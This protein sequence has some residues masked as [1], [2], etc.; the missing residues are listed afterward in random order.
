MRWSCRRVLLAS[1]TMAVQ[2]LSGDDYEMMAMSGLVIGGFA[3]FGGYGSVWRAVL[4]VYVYTIINNVLNLI[5]AGA[6]EQK[7]GCPGSHSGAG[8]LAGRIYSG[9]AGR[10]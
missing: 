7:L 5:G 1:R 4:G 6:Y 9:E 8:S 2:A 10:R 3:V